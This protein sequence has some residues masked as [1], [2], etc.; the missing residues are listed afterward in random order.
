VREGKK[1]SKKLRPGKEKFL[2]R[3]NP[4]KTQQ[5]NI[6]KPIHEKKEIPEREEIKKR[7]EP[8]RGKMW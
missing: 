8:K 4:R 5:R 6:L 2:A 3:T 7:K 1:S